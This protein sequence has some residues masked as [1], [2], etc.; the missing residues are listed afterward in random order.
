MNRLVLAFLAA[1]ETDISRARGIFEYLA[2]RMGSGTLAALTPLAARAFI[3]VQEK[4]MEKGPGGV[5]LARPDEV[6][7]ASGQTDTLYASAFTFVDFGPSAN[8]FL[9]NCGVK[10]EPS[11]KDIARLLLRSPERILEQA[12]RER[13]LEQLR[14]LATNINN[15]DSTMLKAMRETPFVLASQLVLKEKRTGGSGD[16][17]RREWVLTRA[18]ETVVADSATLHSFF[19]EFVLTAPEEAILESFYR[20]LGA[21]A[22]SACVSTEY[23]PNGI[24]QGSSSDAVRSRAFILERLTIFL[25]HHSRRVTDYTADWLAKGDNFTVSEASGIL[26]R[27]TYRDGRNVHQHVEVGSVVFL[28]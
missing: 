1:P 26:A 15:F 16:D 12:G 13:Y 17:F 19:G 21:K 22:L 2:S 18:G 5:R 6:F 8:M 4:K 24:R 20:T 11:T 14:I 3:P 9:R 25:G 10:S 27:Y 28:R 23:V 7:L